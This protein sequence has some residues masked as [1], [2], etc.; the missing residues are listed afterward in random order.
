MKKIYSVLLCLCMLPIGGCSSQKTDTPEKTDPVQTNE[1]QGNEKDDKTD[2]EEKP[3]KC[4]I[5]SQVLYEGNGIKITLK[6]TEI[7]NFN[8]V[9]LPLMLENESERPVTVQVRDISINNIMYDAVFSSEIAAGKKANDSLQ[10]YNGDDRVDFAFVSDIEFKFHIFDGETW[11]TI[12]DTEQIYL[13]TSNEDYQ[14]MPMKDGEVLFDQKGVTITYQ[15]LKE[16]FGEVKVLLL[17][18]N[19]SDTYLCTQVRDSSINGFMVDSIMSSDILPGKSAYTSIGF[20]KSYLEENEITMET[21]EEIEFYFH[22]FEWDSWDEYID[23]D[24]ITL[25][26]Q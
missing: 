24:I 2:T 15:G 17:I 23:S 16:D 3:V 25:K 1:S 11:D 4:T 19:T 10:F 14:Y 9:E 20:L 5:D 18:E 26:I 21:I 12:E 6:E 8:R 22:I 13:Q 7:K